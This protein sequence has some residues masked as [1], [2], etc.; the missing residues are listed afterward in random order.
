LK[1][2]RGVSYIETT[3]E[4][5]ELATRLMNELM[6]RSLDD[7]PPQTRRLLAIIGEMAAG[8][9]GFEFTRRDVRAHTGWGATQVRIHLERLEEL[10]YLITRRGGRG[11]MFVYEYDPNLAGPEGSLAGSKR[12]QNGAVAGSVRS[13]DKPVNIAPNGAF[14]AEAGNCMSQGA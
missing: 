2:E 12:A 10:E 14:H 7:L 4:D 6:R 9:E 8:R 13:A 1:S 3:R 11:Q 5:I